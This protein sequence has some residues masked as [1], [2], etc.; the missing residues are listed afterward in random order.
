MDAD[1]SMDP[2][3]ILM[4]MRSFSNSGADIVN[5]FAS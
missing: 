5:I 2:A 1:G 4:F 3:D